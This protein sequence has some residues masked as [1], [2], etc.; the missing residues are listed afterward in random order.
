MRSNN[1]ASMVARGCEG[2][3][4]G[5]VSPRDGALDFAQVVRAHWAALKRRALWLTKTDTDAADLVQETLVRAMAATRKQ[6]DPVL[7][8]RWLLTIMLNL[9]LDDCRCR[10]ARRVV[11]NP[12]RTLERLPSA[13][14]E[15]PSLWRT[16]SDEQI[17]ACVAALP[18]CLR[19]TYQLYVSGWSY[20]EL[21]QHFQISKD[22]VGTRLHR[23]RKAIRRL[24]CS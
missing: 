20:K 6:S 1:S 17:G 23:I 10:A 11:S 16:A 18:V 13:E 22:T 15:P 21:A 9:F 19:E 24:L 8:L 14:P 7:V 4:E 5:H 2:A 3:G 12:D